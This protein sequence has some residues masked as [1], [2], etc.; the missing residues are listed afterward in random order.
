MAH[1]RCLFCLPVLLVLLA[2]CRPQDDLAQKSEKT[3]TLIHSDKFKEAEPLVRECLRQAPVG[4]YFLS[5]LDIVLNGQ[6][7]FHDA[8]ELRDHIRGIWKEKFRGKSPARGGLVSKAGW[9][10]VVACA[11]DY[12]IIGLEYFTPHFLSGTG[13]EDPLLLSSFY[14]IEAIPIQGSSSARIFLLDRF[15]AEKK[16]F[17]EEFGPRSITMA[18]AY[19][20]KPDIRAVVKDAIKYLDQR[21]R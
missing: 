11:K 16:Y 5:Q 10:R 19:D 14:E 17:L 8:D 2:S 20:E 9:T 21:E 6:G 18:A 3:I 15:K 4:L 1:T 12:Q 7:K 13:S